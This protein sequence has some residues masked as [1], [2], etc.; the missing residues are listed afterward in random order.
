MPGFDGTGPDGMG[1][2]SGRGLGPCYRGG[3][4]GRRGD[5]RMS[6]RSR[7]RG[8]GRGFGRF[9]AEEEDRTQ[10]LKTYK[11]ELEAEIASV[12]EELKNS[13]K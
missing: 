8:F 12:E 10:E 9:Q 3:G 5:C 2:I 11:K 6:I 7:G 13:E 1:P 4:F